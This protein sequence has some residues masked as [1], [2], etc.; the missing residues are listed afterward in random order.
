MNESNQRMGG[1]Q[2]WRICI[3]EK[4]VGH[5]LEIAGLYGVTHFLKGSK[6]M[7][8]GSRHGGRVLN[9]RNL[10][11]MSPT[12]HRWGSCSGIEDYDLKVSII[13]SIRDVSRNLRKPLLAVHIIHFKLRTQFIQ[14]NQQL[15]CLDILK[16]EE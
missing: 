9:T 8:K 5:N 11:A 4:P 2:K 1:I 7:D 6:E 10:S 12:Y 3:S 13:M 16:H 14:G 15:S